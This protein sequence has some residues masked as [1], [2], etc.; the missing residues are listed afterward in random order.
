MN[1]KKQLSLCMI[2]KNNEES[3]PACLDALKEVVD[4][5]IIAD[6][7][8]DDRTI[9][10]AKAKGA[11]VYQIKWENSFSKAKNY[12]IDHANG[13]WILF[14][15]AN[16]SIPG[17]YLE[18]MK[19]LLDNPNAEGYLIYV[20]HQ[21]E[22]VV[23]PVQSLRLLRNRRE[24][25]FRFKSFE[26]I[27]DEHIANIQESHFKI[28]HHSGDEASREKNLRSLLLQED[29]L[30]HPQDG[31][32]QYIYGIELLN[33]GDYEGSI[34]HFQN[35]REKINAEYLFAPHLY[36]CLGWSLLFLERYA[37]AL[38]V[39]NEG[40]DYF[41]FYTDLMVI[42]A[43]LHK[44]LKQYEEAARD[45]K[46]CLL[47]REQP[48]FLVPEP[49]IDASIVCENLA[50]IYELTFNYREALAYYQQACELN[51]EN[52]DC[53]YKIGGLA[54]KAN[55]VETVE[56]L[57][58]AAM[59][60][61]NSERVTV[62]IEILFQQRE[63]SEILDHIEDLELLLGKGDQTERVRISCEIMQG[64][65]QESF[66]NINKTNIYY[67]ELLLERINSCWYNDQWLQGEELLEEMD[68]ITG[69]DPWAKAAYHLIH[70]LLTGKNIQNTVISQ[71][72]YETVYARHED[73]LWLKQASKAKILLPL[74]LT[75]QED[76][77][78][79]RLAQSWAEHNNLSVVQMLFQCIADER[80]KT[81]FIQLVTVQLIRSGYTQTAEEVLGLGDSQPFAA[82][83]Q[84][85]WSRGFM[86]RIEEWIGGMQNI[87][88]E[89]AESGAAALHM[90]NRS[91]KSLLGFY[92]SLNKAANNIDEDISKDDEPEITC[93]EVHE[94]IGDIY[95]KTNKRR[96]AL[97]AYLRVLQWDPKNER[98]QDEIAE[99]FNENPSLFQSCEKGQWVCEGNWFQYKQ[100]FIYYVYGMVSFRNQQYEKALEFFSQ[101]PEGEKCRPVF[102][103]YRASILWLQGKET[104]IRM[105]RREMTA[106][107][108]QLFYSICK[109]CIVE[110]LNKSCQQYLYHDLIE[111]E[112]E[113]VQNRVLF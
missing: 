24:Y 91:L 104:E 8:S 50:E 38:E 53:L 99:F 102:L 62:L 92:Q 30:E 6:I 69:I 10:V 113:R 48:A 16:E 67:N 52:Y 73:F 71:Q 80:K 32:L 96:E 23:S 97:S 59:E 78:Y 20:D 9:D 29:M 51:P 110:K 39:L 27:P 68:R 98:V 84:I 64:N 2:T 17:E 55:A 89:A 86:N 12:C 26:R 25:R 35:A 36:K 74:L 31:Y 40:V 47:I 11:D 42:R 28:I 4:E 49:E 106:D 108:I 79:I 90:D 76:D 13:R 83:R 88:Q 34:E 7:G 105:D 70:E 18:R 37:D 57:F 14:L 93:A 33:K 75:G 45:L 107:F 61:K 21:E 63:Y 77:Q 111:D 22:G 72:E 3:L 43:E 5:I 54:R 87:M 58:H 66:S 46:G 112:I 15:Q 44:Q 109:G 103:A 94:K 82:L 95:V 81:E 1:G 19:P 101:N 41:P 60:E 100:D 65:A 85:L 56:G